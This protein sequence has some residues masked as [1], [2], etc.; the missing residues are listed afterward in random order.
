MFQQNDRAVQALSKLSAAL[1]HGD[2]VFRR[3]KVDPLQS[4]FNPLRVEE[5]AVVAVGAVSF[6]PS[7][8][9]RFS[10]LT[11]DGKQTACHCGPSA[12]L[13][14]QTWE[15]CKMELT[16]NGLSKRWNVWLFAMGA[17]A[18]RMNGVKWST[19]DHLF[20]LSRKQM[21]VAI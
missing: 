2:Q 7:I 18:E 14:T 9:N 16:N 4:G 20:K 3:M 17:C 10:A 12:P 13:C 8:Q 1:H 19:T 6:G 15:Y 11:I 21:D 5:I